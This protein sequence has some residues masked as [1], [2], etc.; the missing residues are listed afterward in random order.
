MK[1][2][3]EI[4]ISYSTQDK[5]LAECIQK[6]AGSLLGITPSQRQQLSDRVFLSDNSIPGGMD[7]LAT[8]DNAISKTKV[9]I[10]LLTPNSIYSPWV[11]YEIGAAQITHKLRW[12][13]RGAQVFPLLAGGLTTNDFP[14]DMSS[15]LQSL[16]LQFCSAY[17]EDDLKDFVQALATSLGCKK[18]IEEACV[19]RCKELLKL[20]KGC[21]EGWGHTCMGRNILRI[22]SSPYVFE[23][24]IKAPSTKRLFIA[25]Q[26][27]FSLLRDDQ[28]NGLQK[29]LLQELKTRDDLNVRILI[30]D[31]EYKPFR[32]SWNLL[33]GGGQG[34]ASDLAQA[35]RNLRMLHDNCHPSSGSASIKGTFVARVTK[36]IPVSATF[37]NADDQ[38]TDGDAVIRPVLG[39]EPKQR[40]AFCV[41]APGPQKDIYCYYWGI[42]DRIWD[43][44]NDRTRCI[45]EVKVPAARPK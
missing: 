10:V 30:C 23:R 1:T 39:R 36:V 34:Y 43:D 12:I 2:K 28:K 17:T 21:L 29:I 15:V 24:I 13:K 3:H 7:W 20:S 32:E 37:V 6:I 44:R 33:M 45:T 19:W 11:H 35:T 16:R 22:G 26:N 42:F 4:F 41:T 9:L 40:A 14:T 31:Y 25:G 27:L 5:A 18:G 38:G 8:I